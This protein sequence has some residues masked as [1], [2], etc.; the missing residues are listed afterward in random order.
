MIV[1]YSKA[2]AKGKK[3]LFFGFRNVKQSGHDLHGGG[4]AEA[5]PRGSVSES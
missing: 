5:E 2:C 1:Q 3:E 4:V